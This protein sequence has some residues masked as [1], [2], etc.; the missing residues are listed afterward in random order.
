MLGEVRPGILKDYKLLMLALWNR[1]ML[2]HCELTPAGDDSHPKR[3]TFEMLSG[4]LACLI[5]P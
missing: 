1:L 5:L 3:Y 2:L 4:H